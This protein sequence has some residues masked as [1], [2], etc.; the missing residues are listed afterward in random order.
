MKT[1]KLV[2]KAVLFCLAAAVSMGVARASSPPPTPTNVI[3][4]WSFEMEDTNVVTKIFSGF[5]NCTNVPG[6]FGGPAVNSGIE[7]FHDPGLPEACT[8]GIWDAWLMQSDNTSA[9]QT[10]GYLI[11][12][13]DSYVVSLWMKNEWCHTLAW[14]HTNAYMSIILYYGGTSNTVGNPFFTNTFCILPG[15]ATHTTVTD[16]TNYVFAVIS[17]QVPPAALGQPLG[18]EIWQTTTN[19]NPGAYAASAGWNLMPCL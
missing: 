11:Q 15:S 19:F 1:I 13:V 5:D 4:N 10:T 18:I 6:W 2:T 12:H 16:W 14:V 9:N 7:Y 8:N 17:N 3:Y